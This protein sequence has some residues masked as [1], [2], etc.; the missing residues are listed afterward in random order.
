MGCRFLANNLADDPGNVAVSSARTGLVHMPAPEAAGTAVCYATGDY[1]GALDQIFR[2]EIDSIQE[3]QE[4]GEATFRWKRESTESYEASGVTTSSDMIELTDGV[5]IKWTSGPG[6][7]F[8]EGDGWKILATR[9]FGVQALTDRDRDSYWETG[10]CADENITADC[11]EAVQITALVLADHNLT[12]AATVTLM[13]N[14][15]DE[16]GAPAWQQP[17]SITKPHLVAW[18]NQTYQFW[19]L[20]LADAANPDGVIRASMLYLGTYF[21]PS[22]TYLLQHG[23][24]VNATRR[25]N[26]A[27]G[28][29]I[30]GSSGALSNDLAL[31]FVGLSDADKI[32]F[33]EWHR[34]VHDQ[35]SGAL[36]PMFF[37]P[38]ANDPAGMI[39]CTPPASLPFN[40]T[41]RGRH[42]ISLQLTE[43][44]KS[45]S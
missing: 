2:I 27:Y 9:N 8:E 41:A 14:P 29:K 17:L 43:V 39:Y 24:T 25:T 1:T 35:E 44:V 32:G 40:Q 38:A 31:P 3:G 6:N 7:D 11:G 16:W 36:N 10:G 30:T 20:A 15:T 33:K 22:R 26:T 12:D 4:V 37:V 5:W 18:L 42:S 34:A 23:E 21:E 13:A 28:G 45:G 19:R